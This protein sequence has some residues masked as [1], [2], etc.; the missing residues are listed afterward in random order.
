MQVILRDIIT[1]NETIFRKEQFFANP[2]QYNVLL[3]TEEGDLNITRIIPYHKDKKET[4]LQSLREAIQTAGTIATR[5]GENGLAYWIAASN[6]Q[7]FLYGQDF[8]KSHNP[9]EIQ[10][11]EAWAEDEAISLG[12]I[13]REGMNVLDSF[14][15]FNRLAEHLLSDYEHCELENGNTLVYTY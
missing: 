15:D 1:N 3:S 12:F 6:D 13:S 7:G 8:V 10:N 2:A 4:F 9:F 5:D 11:L 14:I